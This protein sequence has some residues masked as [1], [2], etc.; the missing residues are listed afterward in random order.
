[1]YLV[2]TGRDGQIKTWRIRSVRNKSGE[3]DDFWV[4][5]STYSFR[6]EIP[7]HVS[8]SSDGS[9]LCVSFGS[10]VALFDP[11][12]NALHQILTSPHCKEVSSAFF[13]GQSSRYLAVVGAR[14]VLLWDLVAQTIRW[15][16]RSTSIIERIVPHSREETFAVFERGIPTGPG[17]L[18]TQVVTLNASSPIPTGMY[19]VPFHLRNVASHA[20]LNALS[21]NPTSFTLVGI[22]TSWS[23]VVFGDDVRLPEENGSR[24]NEIVDDD[25]LRP[26]T[27]FQD[28]FGK[29]AF[30]DLTSSASSPPHGAEAIQLWR[31][32]EVAEIFDAPAYLLP[33]LESVFDALTDGFLSLRSVQDSHDLSEDEREQDGD[34]DM[35]ADEDHTPVVAGTTIERL[36]SAQEMDAFVELFKQHA[37]K[38][39][40]PSHAVS[41]PPT[42]GIHKP[43]GTP[44]HSTAPAATLPKQPR[45]NGSTPKPAAQTTYVTPTPDA[46]TSPMVA[47]GKKRKKSVG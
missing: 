41:Q 12:T 25:N 40:A 18:G 47:T 32:K 30:A 9:V 20:S 46:E 44:K 39:P 34:V 4:A 43:N 7:K 14:D 22:T 31:G 26:R 35:D 3:T 45:L 5:R 21:T 37:L 2:S 6:S 23:F 29:S 13:V 8:W 17:E 33:P 24:A 27:L 36:V 16:Y 11:V 15:Q 1:L 42:N 38:A 19:T 28:I 10:H